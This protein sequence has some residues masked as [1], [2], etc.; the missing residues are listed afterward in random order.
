MAR[1]LRH[2]YHRLSAQAP[3]RHLVGDDAQDGELAGG[4][5]AREGWRHRAGTG[6]QPASIAR[7]GL[8]GARDVSSGREQARTARWDADGHDALTDRAAA[9]VEAFGE[10]LGVVVAQ[11]TGAVPLPDLA[12]NLVHLRE[13]ARAI[14]G[15]G[16]RHMKH[17]PRSL[18]G[19]GRHKA[20]LLDDGI[21]VPS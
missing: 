2:A 16:H 17:R 10:R 13:R 8:V 18:S 9:A 4:E 3:R 12:R 14:D 6:Q 15:G 11:S 21:G 20:R 1:P 19:R 7:G 5:A